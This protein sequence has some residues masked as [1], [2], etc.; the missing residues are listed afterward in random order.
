M[1]TKTILAIPQFSNL[2]PLQNFYVSDLALHLKKH[3]KLIQKLHAHD[4]YV[5]V[6]FT[7]GTGIHVIDFKSYQIAPGRIFFLHPGQLHTWQFTLP[8]QGYIFFHTKDFLDLM[9]PPHQLN[10]FPF[11]YSRQNTPELT[12]NSTELHFVLPYFK[13][14]LQ[15]YHSDENLMKYNKIA[16]LIQV[17]YISLSRVYVTKKNTHTTIELRHMKIVHDFE[18]LIYLNFRQ[19]NTLVTYADTL[20]LST[21]HLNRIVSSF[22][23]K[24][25]KTLLTEHVI[26]QCKM[27]L[28][29]SDD[30]LTDVALKLGFNEL[31]YFSKFFKKHEGITPLAFRGKYIM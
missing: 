14:V 5:C 25:A 23:G 31:S 17:I 3:D 4:F 21:K 6:I 28:I 12:I 27:A 1:N 24:T 13:D 16:S 10:H 15:E 30:S 22:T 9:F 18:E 2:N 7:A 29:N 11:Y 26:L 20:G 19:W 8:A